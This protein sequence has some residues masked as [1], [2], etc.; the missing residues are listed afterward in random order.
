MWRD[1]HTDL[2]KNCRKVRQRF[3]NDK[4]GCEGMLREQI[5]RNYTRDNTLTGLVIIPKEEM[6][7]LLQW[8]EMRRDVKAVYRE[9]IFDAICNL[10]NYISDYDVEVFQK[11]PLPE[12]LDYVANKKTEFLTWYAQNRKLFVDESQILMTAIHMPVYHRINDHGMLDLMV[13]Y[14]LC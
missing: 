14:L 1:I 12:Q 11:K 3:L 7:A 9:V 5:I 4:K 8:F 10:W 13:S 6:A 2:E